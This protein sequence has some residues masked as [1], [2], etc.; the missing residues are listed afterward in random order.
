MAKSLWNVLA[1][2]QGFPEREAQMYVM[3]FENLLGLV[4]PLSSGGVQL[5]D[6]HRTIVRS[7][8]S[9]GGDGAVAELRMIPVVPAL[10]P[11]LEVGINFLG[12]RPQP[13]AAVEDRAVLLMLPWVPG[14]SESAIGRFEIDFAIAIQR[15]LGPQSQLPIVANWVSRN[16][17]ITV[18]GIDGLHSSFS[19]SH[20]RDTLKPYLADHLKR[21]AEFAEPHGAPTA[22]PDA[23]QT[24]STGPRPVSQTEPGAGPAPPRKRPAPTQPSRSIDA[25]QSPQPGELV[26]IAGSLERI[27]DS[28]ERLVEIQQSSAP[29]VCKTYPIESFKNF[30]FEAIG[31]V[32]MQRDRSGVARISYRGKVYTRRSPTNSKFDPA[33]FFSRSLPKGDSKESKYEEVIRFKK[34]TSSVEDI[35]PR[36]RNLIGG[37]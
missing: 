9:I 2:M 27:A 25:P 35:D 28:L 26:K 11:G 18:P 17:D 36:V 13:T 12:H 19:R 22:S 7:V 5:V 16:R 29:V 3:D 20:T 21:F 8:Q 14:L 15:C 4:A 6:Y 34:I 33:I 37:G 1:L 24:T 23:G 10:E 32:V 30:D 31:M